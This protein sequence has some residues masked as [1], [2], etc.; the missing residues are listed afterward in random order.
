MTNWYYYDGNGSK[1]GTYPSFTFTLF[2]TLFV[3]ITIW[4]VNIL[5]ILFVRLLGEFIIF[6]LDWCV[7]TRLAAQYTIANNQHNSLIKQTFRQ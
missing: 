1:I 5:T 2:E 6:M 3:T 4:V 7:D